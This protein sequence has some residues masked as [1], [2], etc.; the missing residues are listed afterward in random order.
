[1]LYETLNQPHIL[2]ILILAG[3]LSGIIF[4][5]VN[6]IKFLC[7]N[8]KVVA[9]I[10]DFLGTSLSLAILFFVNLN[11][12]YGLI[13]LYPAIIFLLSF[14]IERFTLGKIVAKFYLSC[15]NTFI[16]FIDKLKKKKNE[17]NKDG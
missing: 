9:I 6:F 17:T 8:K 4:D 3:F 14:S 13:R 10:L 1:M 16:K 11:V 2:F 15:Y 12:N 5:V 7:G